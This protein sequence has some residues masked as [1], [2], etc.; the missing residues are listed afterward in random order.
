MIKF[1]LSVYCFMCLG[2]IR[3]ICQTTQRVP[4]RLQD[5]GLDLFLKGFC[6]VRTHYTNGLCRVSF[7]FDILIQSPGFVFT[8]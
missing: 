5:T 3:K 8:S 7:R 6:F 4:V 1:G 2:H